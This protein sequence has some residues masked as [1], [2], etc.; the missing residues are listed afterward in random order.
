M[1]NVWNVIIRHYYSFDKNLLITV[2]CI[3]S[4]AHPNIF[5]T[6]R[7]D[8]YTFKTVALKYRIIINY[9]M[10]LLR[11]INYIVVA[12]ARFVM[13]CYTYYKKNLKRDVAVVRITNR[14]TR[15]NSTNYFAKHR[16]RVMIIDLYVNGKYEMWPQYWYW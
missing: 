3:R 10:R 14:K 15:L 13:S 9:N 6:Q 1:C 5:H 16:N 12:R 2:Y 8:D 11:F 4:V 7:I